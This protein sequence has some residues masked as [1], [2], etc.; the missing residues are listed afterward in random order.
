VHRIPTQW[1]VASEVVA[2]TPIALPAL[3]SVPRYEPST[4]DSDAMDGSRY[5]RRVSND[6][7]DPYGTGD[8]STALQTVLSYIW[9]SNDVPRGIDGCFDSDTYPAT[10]QFQQDDSGVDVD[11]IVVG[12]TWNR[13]QQNPRHT[14]STSSHQHFRPNQ[15]IR[16]IPIPPPD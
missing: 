15:T 5:S 7:G 14:S 11:G 9:Q 12:S 10:R 3:A 13:I 2:L 8:F 4:C 16:L 1:I 6:E